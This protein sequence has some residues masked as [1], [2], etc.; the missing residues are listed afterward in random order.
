[1]KVRI[2]KRPNRHAFSASRRHEIGSKT[3]PYDLSGGFLPLKIIPCQEKSRVPGGGLFFFRKPI[4]I[5][6]GEP[7]GHMLPGR[8]G[9]GELGGAFEE[10]ESSGLYGITSPPARNPCSPRSWPSRPW[11]RRR[12][13]SEL[14]TEP[15][16]YDSHR[17]RHRN[18]ER[19]GR[20]GDHNND[21]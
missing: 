11:P 8:K 18:F 3:K 10:G 14:T 15:L 6:Q 17:T 12:L 1:M 16:V 19:I 7:R 9:D 2:L 5:P 13:P 20:E 4:Y 21:G